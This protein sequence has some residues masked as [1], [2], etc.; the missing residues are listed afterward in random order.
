MDAILQ[1]L[2][3]A[4]QFR[5]R[6]TRQRI[7]HP[8]LVALHLHHSA[9]AKVS[10]VLGNFRLRLAE[11]RLEMTDTK[12]RLRKQIQD[13]KPGPVAEALV[14]VNEIHRN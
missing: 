8:V 2:E 11:N 1:A 3:I 4:F 13:P 10:E 7:N 14:D 12:R 6:F 5:R 9:V